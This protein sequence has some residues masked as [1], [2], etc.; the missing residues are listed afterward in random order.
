[1]IDNSKIFRIYDVDRHTYRSG[2]KG[3]PAWLNRKAVINAI[4][5]FKKSYKGCFEVHELDF[6]NGNIKYTELE[7]K[8]KYY[9]YD[10]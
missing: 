9:G 10:E 5:G 7:F 2:F 3:R 8:K 1:M 6:I 4:F